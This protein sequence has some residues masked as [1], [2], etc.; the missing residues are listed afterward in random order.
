MSNKKTNYLKTPKPS[1]EAKEFNYGDVPNP[2]RDKGKTGYKK[3]KELLNP[4]TK[5]KYDSLKKQIQ[6]GNIDY[7]ISK[8]YSN[9]VRKVNK[10]GNWEEQHQPSHLDMNYQRMEKNIF[11]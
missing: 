3:S 11:L 7:S 5:K 8:N 2:L 1:K 4:S 10:G 6:M 9:S